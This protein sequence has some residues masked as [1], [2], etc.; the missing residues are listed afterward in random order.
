MM[1][2]V[3]LAA[4]AVQ[5]LGDFWGTERA[6]EEYYRIV[7]LPFDPALALEAGSMCA[8][9]D[10][11]LAIGTRRGEILL[12]T[13]AF[14]EIPQPRVQ[15]FAS[16]LDEVLGLGWRDGAFYATQQTELTRI[17]DRDGDTATARM[18]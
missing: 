16:G 14:D 18:I 17:T 3:T 13:G 11:R 7:E 12:V 8:L 2:L 5:E 1:M 15:R 6:E 10:G 4:L 9:P